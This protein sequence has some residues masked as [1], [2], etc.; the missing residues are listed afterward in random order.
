MG[1]TFRSLV[2]KWCDLEII[3]VSDPWIKNKICFVSAAGDDVTILIS[4]RYSQ[5][6]YN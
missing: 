6:L 3:G 2:Y 1:N 5:A 4:F